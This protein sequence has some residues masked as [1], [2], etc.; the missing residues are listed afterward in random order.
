MTP[1]DP[2]PSLY[3]RAPADDAER[4]AVAC[5]D[6]DAWCESVSPDDR[7][8][9]TRPNGHS[10]DHVTAAYQDGWGTEE[11]LIYARWP[12]SPDKGA[13]EEARPPLSVQARFAGMERDGDEFTMRMTIP[14]SPERRAFWER[15]ETWMR[16]SWV[17]SP[18]P[19]PAP[20]MAD[21]AADLV[22]IGELH[23]TPP[24]PIGDCACYSLPCAHYPRG[25]DLA[26]PSPPSGAP[27]CEHPNTCECCG[28]R[29][30][31]KAKC[32]DCLD[33]IQD[34]ASA[35]GADVL[36]FLRDPSLAVAV[37][38]GVTVERAIAAVEQMVNSY[39]A[40]LRGKFACD[41]EIIALRE[42]RDA[43]RAQLATART[44]AL[45]EAAKRAISCTSVSRGM[46][47]RLH[48]SV[49]V[50][51]IV[52]EIR[53]LAPQSGQAAAVVGYNSEDGDPPSAPIYRRNPIPEGCETCAGCPDCLTN[54]P[55]HFTCDG[56][57]AMP[58]CGSGCWHNDS[59]HV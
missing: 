37:R 33:D 47:S 45:E 4:E 26:E 40:V 20:T 24:A 8:G 23:S 57:H 19:V 9:C 22:S 30:H 54:K 11:Q 18:P 55:P 21:I 48:A 3:P 42:E 29:I 7:N 14:A 36:A 12:A 38:G 49:L 28:A 41:A 51:F 52:D 6:C 43:L 44:E 16:L 50:D 10:G 13:P 25:M 53:A 15:T 56:D 1:D 31:L 2:R 39:A 5:D 58:S 35:E 32:A 27:A 46:G 59:R 34:S 17:A